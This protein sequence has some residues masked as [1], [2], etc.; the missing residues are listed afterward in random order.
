[1]LIHGWGRRTSSFGA[2]IPELT[3]NGSQVIRF[4]SPCHGTSTKRKTSFF[5]MSDLVKLFL[6]KDTYDL[7]ITHSM[8]TVLAFIAMSSLKYKVN[9]MIVLTTSSRFLEFIGLAVAQFGLTTKTT[10]L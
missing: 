5:E 4:D 7:I 10:K 3:K 9:Q 8:G 6:Q 2:I 1:M